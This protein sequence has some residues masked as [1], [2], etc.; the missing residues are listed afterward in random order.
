MSFFQKIKQALG[1]VGV[2]VTL[3]VD[4]AVSRSAGSIPGK[5]IIT[6]KSD[7][8]ILGL[9]IELEETW[10]IGKGENEQTKTFSLGQWKDDSSFDIKAGETREFPFNLYF[11][12]VKSENDR[13]M[14]SSKVGKAL[15]SLGKMLDGENSTYSLNASADV[16]GAALD[17]NCCREIKL[18]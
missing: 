11:S 5:M 7:Q 18:V 15:G 16:K 12:L 14:E 8:H 2:K 1:F 13:M 10:T 6:S 9:E 4:A 17:P 3:E